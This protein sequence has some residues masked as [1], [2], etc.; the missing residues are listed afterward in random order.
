MAILRNGGLSLEIRYLKSEYANIQYDICLRWRDKPVLN[1]A[2]LRR[3][4]DYWAIR[5]IGSV[6]AEEDYR[7]GLL[8]LLQVVIENNEAD[9][10]GPTEPDILL[11]LYPHRLYPGGTFPF[12]PSGQIL[13]REEEGAQ[14]VREAREKERETFEPLPDDYID[15]ILFVDTK[16]FEYAVGYSGTGI[17][18]RLGPT[19]AELQEFYETLKK[20]F[21][22]YCEEWGIPPRPLI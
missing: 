11:A 13:L 6:L 5:G 22:E 21:L 17:C 4:N 10:W 18:F 7:C 3:E 12:L 1:D 8:T 9:F 16:I 19:R 2:V 15:L 14:E 20:E